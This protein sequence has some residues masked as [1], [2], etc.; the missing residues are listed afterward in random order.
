MNAGTMFYFWQYCELS[1]I[2]PLQLAK[3]YKIKFN[4]LLN[5]QL[6]E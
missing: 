3:K 4:V 5:A 1:N 2:K 6:R